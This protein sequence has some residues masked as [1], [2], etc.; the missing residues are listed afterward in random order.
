MTRVDLT[1]S[2]LKQWAYCPRIVYYGH[3][4]GRMGRA[5]W[6]M[7]EGKSAE[8]MFEKLEV[9][10]RL[11]KYRLDGAER[12]FRVWLLDEEL[13][14]C[15]KADLLLCGSEEV[16]AVDFKLT[17]GMPGANHRMQLAGYS[18]LAERATGLVARRAF[19]Y[20]I[21]D[22]R[23][24]EFPVGEKER[25]AVRAAIGE[26][27]RMCEVEELPAATDVRGRCVECEF[28]NFCG[29]VW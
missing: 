8:D 5:T 29:D 24:F 27:R 21:P 7:G 6:K 9:R 3:V 12:R 4:M 2:D 23:L 11:A 10:R 13:G 19:V 15:G 18:M 25:D 14:L 22:S 1:V 16:A 20:R 28:Q 17:S 26:I